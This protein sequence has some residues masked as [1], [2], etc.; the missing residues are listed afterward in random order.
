MS[1]SIRVPITKYN[2]ILSS[3]YYGIDTTSI[4]DLVYEGHMNKTEYLQICHQ[5]QT[6]LRP[7]NFI[8]TAVVGLVI[9]SGLSFFLALII[10][11]NS[12]VYSVWVLGLG[13]VFL[14]VAGAVSYFV[15]P[16][17]MRVGFQHIKSLCEKQSSRHTNEFCESFTLNFYL[18]DGLAATPE[19]FKPEEYS[20]S[21][22]K[23]AH[24]LYLTIN[25]KSKSF[26][27]DPEIGMATKEE[28]SSQWTLESIFIKDDSST[29]GTTDTDDDDTTL[30][31]I[32]LDYDDVE[33]GQMKRSPSSAGK[34]KKK[35]RRKY[36]SQHEPSDLEK[37]LRKIMS[38]QEQEDRKER[39]KKSKKKGKRT[40]KSSHSRTE[41]ETS[42]DDTSIVFV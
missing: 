8:R 42:S 20:F 4:P 40:K 38:L 3:P 10:S 1:S 25:V 7:I 21:S 35:S 29:I 15:V 36:K 32:S 13:I 26:S 24:N 27:M 37:E 30:R 39:R 41:I 33:D 2:T 19:R 23:T 34:Q 14:L 22:F 17:K 16:S 5:I 12:T 6:F 18:C 28:G 31:D 11:A 9:A